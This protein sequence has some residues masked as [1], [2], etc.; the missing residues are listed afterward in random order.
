MK[1]SGTHHRGLESRA[2]EVVEGDDTLD[3][4]V[5]SSSVEYHKRQ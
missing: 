3:G 5:A 2:K 4:I 1:A